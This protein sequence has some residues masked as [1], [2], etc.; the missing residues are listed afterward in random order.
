MQTANLW[1]QMITEAECFPSCRKRRGRVFF[2]LNFTTL[3]Y[4]QA[5]KQMFPD[6]QLAKNLQLEIIN[7]YLPLI[8][9]VEKYVRA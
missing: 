9:R 4:I 6:E 8:Y 1:T 5:V 2:N 3:S 7:Q